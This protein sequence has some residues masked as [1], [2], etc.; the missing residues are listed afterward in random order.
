MRRF[1]FLLTLPCLLAAEDRWIK[2]TSGPF[3]VFTDAGARAGRETMVRLEEF[4]HAVGQIVGEQD[5]ETPQPVRVLLFKNAKGWA[6]ADPVTEARDRYAI[7]LEEKA[8]IS[9]AVY[10]ALTRLFLNANTSRMPPSFERGL[11]EFFSTFESKGVRITV[12]APPAG[13][14]YGPDLDWARVHLLVVDP[15]YFGRIRVLL[16]NLRSGV[17]EDTCFRNAFG[18]SAAEVEAQAKQHFAAGNFQTGTISGLPMADRDLPERTVSDTDARLARADLLA[19][20]PSAAEYEALLRDHVKVAE[21]EEGLGL[22]ALRDHHNDDARRHFAAATEAGSVSARCYI[23]YARLEPDNE[24]ATQALLKAAGINPKLDEPFALL[25]AR[26][27]DPQKR[28]EHWKAAAERNPRNPAYWK[29]L[30]ECYL[31]DHNYG[32]AAK[33]WTGGEQAATDPAERER[34]RQARL[35]IE[36]QRLDHD[37]AE[38]RRQAEEEA[39]E[40]EKLKQEALA[41]VRQLEARNSDGARPSSDAPVPWW[42]GPQ[43]SG[44]V[45]GTLRQVDCLG[46]QARLMVEGDDHKTVRLLVADPSKVAIAGRGQQTLGCGKQAPRA[47]SIEYF[48]KVNARLGTAGEVATIEFQ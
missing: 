29:A 13:A 2:F 18:K 9:P 23:E 24:K 40:T 19:G 35:A 33:A 11:I 8:V 1:F 28:L 42:E 26:D 45:R 5:L 25:A 47:V 21:A 41:R 4:R 46:S 20:A 48:P 14:P 43:P 22:L 3:E 38:K 17:D 27:T 10:G 12:G 16:Y 44:K 37:E 15:Q 30:A 39:R 32:E 7:V 31:A 6:T 36:Q 34:M